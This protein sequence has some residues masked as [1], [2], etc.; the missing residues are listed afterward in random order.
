MAH[1]R[2]HNRG[3]RVCKE[4]ADALVTRK[5]GEGAWRDYVCAGWACGE[6]LFEFRFGCEGMLRIERKEEERKGADGDK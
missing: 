5:V 1:P 3:S 6:L 4:A 2:K